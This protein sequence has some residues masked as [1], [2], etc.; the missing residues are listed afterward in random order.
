[1]KNKEKELYC[2][3]EYFMKHN[4]HGCK[5]GRKCQ[6]WN[7]NRIKRNCNNRNAGSNDN[8]SKS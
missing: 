6:E 4:C 5:L 8:N 2:G 3:F 7:E 1:M